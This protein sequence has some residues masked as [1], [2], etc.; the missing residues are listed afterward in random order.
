MT[1]CNQACFT[2]KIMLHR[3]DNLKV[4]LLVVCGRYKRWV[5]ILKA[6]K[7]VESSDFVRNSVLPKGISIFLIKAYC[8]FDISWD[9]DTV[10]EDFVEE[11]L[12]F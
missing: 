3:K 9:L 11:I 12:L 7:F 1:T 2:T 6:I 8:V 4:C 10:L 5:L